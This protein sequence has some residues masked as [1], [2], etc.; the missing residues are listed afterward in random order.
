[1]NLTKT[2]PDIPDNW[3]GNITDTCKVLGDNKPLDR[4][5]LKKYAMLGKRH[6]GIDWRPKLGGKQGMI[7]TG[8]EIKRFWHSYS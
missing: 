5:T 8:K 4:G 7:F 3:R 2:C 1:M 6:G